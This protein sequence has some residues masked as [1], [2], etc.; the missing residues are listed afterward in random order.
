MGQPEELRRQASRLLESLQSS[1]KT[2]SGTVATSVTRLHA[3]GIDL[4]G[5]AQALVRWYEEQ[6]FEAQALPQ[7]DQFIVQCRNRGRWKVAVGLSMSVTV[8]LRRD[9]AELV[10]EISGG[11]WLDKGVVGGLGIVAVP[12]LIAPAAWGAWVQ[13]RMPDRTVD[14]IRAT[15]PDHLHAGSAAAPVPSSVGSRTSVSQASV[16]GSVGQL[17]VN[18]ATADQ[19]GA[20]PGIGLI[21]GKKAVQERVAR[22]GFRSVEDF[23]RAVGSTLKP[24]QFEQLRPR[25]SVSP[26]R[27]TDIP[28][29][30]GPGRRIED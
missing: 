8:V 17:D 1:E 19:I 10:I 27:R 6:K 30:T 20:L 25:L 5:L 16:T 24:H 26:I 18:T 13:A 2:E 15:L 7:A 3:P 23:A 28:T 22:G 9:H 4:F 29:T 11:K 21:L 14:F 12:V